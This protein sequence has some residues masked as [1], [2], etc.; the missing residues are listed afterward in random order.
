M[1]DMHGAKA[2]SSAQGPAGEMQAAFFRGFHHPGAKLKVEKPTLSCLPS[3]PEERVRD[4]WG[5]A[6][7]FLLRHRHQ[8]R[9]FYTFP[10]P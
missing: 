9:N 8:M 10:S 3:S 4:A 6:R 7:P 5:I 2:P 1:G